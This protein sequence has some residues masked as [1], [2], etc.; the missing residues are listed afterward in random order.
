MNGMKNCPYCHASISS[1]GFLGNWEH[2]QCRGCG[3]QFAEEI[4]YSEYEDE[5]FDD[6]FGFD[7]DEY[8]YEDEYPD[9]ADSNYGYYD[10][11]ENEF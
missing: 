7:D 4:M 1:L 2:F 6:D 8:N 11:Y 9:Y 10:E 3:I 5:C